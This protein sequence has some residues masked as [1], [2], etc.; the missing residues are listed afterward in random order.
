MHAVQCEQRVGC[1]ER[2]VKN[3]GI[4]E[5]RERRR[6]GLSLFVHPVHPLYNNNIIG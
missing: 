4:E 5:R 6:E 3:K 1:S 2:K